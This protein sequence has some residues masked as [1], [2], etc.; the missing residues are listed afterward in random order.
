MRLGTQTI[1]VLVGTPAEDELHNK[2]LTWQTPGRTDIPGCSV[3]PGGGGVNE[4]DREATTTIYTVWAPPT[5]VVS[6]INR[7]EYAGT[8]Y[9]V[10]G[11]AERWNVGTRLDHIVIRLRAASG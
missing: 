6:D 8:P 10:D 5:A 9:A 4:S 2:I 3:Q 7:V 1:T 11:P